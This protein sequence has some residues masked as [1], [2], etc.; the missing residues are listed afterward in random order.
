MIFSQFLNKT[1]KYL[2]SVRILKNYVSID[3]VFS[4]S[5]QMIKNKPNGVEI[6]QN[7]QGDGSLVTSF[8]S[9][10]EKEYIDIL[11][12][13]LDEFIKTN[14]E[15][16][17]KEKLFKSKVQELKNIFE[18]EKLENLKALKFDIEELTKFLENEE[19]KSTDIVA[20]TTENV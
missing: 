1:N 10:N 20:E 18:K 6:L 5:W 15:R 12:K 19:P 3:M 4:S 17:E 7:E 8:V 11:E 16:E 13:C 9:L 2:K 14:I